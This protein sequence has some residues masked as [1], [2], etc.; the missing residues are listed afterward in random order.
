MRCWMR[1]LRVEL[2]SQQNQD[3]IVIGDNQKERE[4]NYP[5]GLTAS[6]IGDNLSIKI[7]GTKYP[8]INKDKGVLTIIN[9]DMETRLKIQVGQYYGIKIYCGYKSWNSEPFLIYSGEVSHMST[10]FYSHHDTETYITFASK[11]VAKYS[12]NR[13]NFALNSGLNVYAIMNYVLNANGAT[14]SHLD[15]QLKQKVIE[16][17]KMANGSLS[18]IL[19]SYTF[20]QTGDYTVAV[21][22][23]EG[24]VIDV[25]SIKGKRFIRIDP[26]VIPIGSGN[27]TVSSEGLNIVLLPVCNLKVGD[28][29]VVDNSLI[30]ISI[31][32]AES[33][34]STFN[35][36]Y[37]DSNGY[38]MIYELGFTLENRGSNFQ[39]NIKARALDVLKNLTGI[40]GA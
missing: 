39:Y 26:N 17:Y 4:R 25:T 24:T 35:A 27:P 23:T 22:G 32:N 40:S 18:S 20:T 12:Q 7:Q 13:M 21:D 2:I 6:S 37:M 33:V 30:N 5:F 16:E 28:I 29:L 10:K 15:P 3:K 11:I 36:N 38:Y 14:N 1:L 31:S 9:L 8:A 34:T 19:D